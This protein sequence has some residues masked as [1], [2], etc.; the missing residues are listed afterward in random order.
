MWTDDLS[1]RVP[2]SGTTAEAIRLTRVD[3]H[4]AEAGLRQ[5]RDDR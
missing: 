2:R 4:P 1:A 3:G 5:T